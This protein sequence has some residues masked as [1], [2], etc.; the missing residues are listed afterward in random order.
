MVFRIG[1]IDYTEKEIVKIA[2]AHKKMGIES[3]ATVI[4]TAIKSN[5]NESAEKADKK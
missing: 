2:L 3:G 5:K 4:S 1:D